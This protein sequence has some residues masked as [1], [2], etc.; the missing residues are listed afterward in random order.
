MTNWFKM[1]AQLGARETDSLLALDATPLVGDNVFYFW[2]NRRLASTLGAQQ[3][4]PP[5]QQGNAAGEG[6]SANDISQVIQTTVAALT[7]ILQQS[8]GQQPGTPAGRRSQQKTNK[9]KKYTPE[10]ICGIV[11]FLW[12]FIPSRDPQCMEKI[13]NDDCYRNAPQMDY[14][15]NPGFCWRKGMENQ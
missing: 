2:A 3:Q 5:Q 14:A 1:V 12:S 9:G 15:G 6:M 7:P 11:G 4:T 10:H 13:S 8:Q